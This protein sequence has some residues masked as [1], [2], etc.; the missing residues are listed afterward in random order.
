MELQASNCSLCCT[1]V[2]TELKVRSTV[3]TRGPKL[4]SVIPAPSV[5]SASGE[6]GAK[7]DSTNHNARPKH[8]VSSVIGSDLSNRN[9]TPSV[10][11][12][13]K[14]EP[15]RIQR[16]ELFISDIADIA[17]V[18]SAYHGESCAVSSQAGVAP[19]IEIRHFCGTA[20]QRSSSIAGSGRFDSQRRQTVLCDRH[21]AR[22]CPGPSRHGDPAGQARA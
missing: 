21:E 13:D 10:E 6:S 8:L 1:I 5:F 18:P 3:R 22:Q 14:T 12:Q 7:L 9:P 17:L 15:S 16:S 4:T 2:P 11:Y 19:G 20:P